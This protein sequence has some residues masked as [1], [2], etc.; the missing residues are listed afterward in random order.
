[1]VLI[2]ELLQ[3]I[4]NHSTNGI[5]KKRFGGIGGRREFQKHLAFGQSRRAW[6]MVSGSALQNGQ[7]GEIPSP[8]SLRIALIAMLEWQYCQRK[9]FTLG[10]DKIF[11]TQVPGKRVLFRF[12][13]LSKASLYASLSLNSPFE[14]KC[15]VS[16]SSPWQ[17]NGRAV[18]FISKRVEVGKEKET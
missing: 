18:A 11:H 7:T 14:D 4:F 5:P 6:T 1:M 12:S 13:S 16:L 17:E 15:H 9:C 2:Q 8:L 10:R 3:L